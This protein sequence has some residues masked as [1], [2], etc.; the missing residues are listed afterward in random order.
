MFD[1]LKTAL[2]RLWHPYRPELYYMR[3][4][5]PKTALKQKALGPMTAPTPAGAIVQR[6]VPGF[7]AIAEQSLQH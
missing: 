5:G 1:S 4:P 7:S 3:G 2:D 6:Q